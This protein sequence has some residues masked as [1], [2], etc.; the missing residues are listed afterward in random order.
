MD[1]TSLRNLEFPYVLHLEK[2]AG[3]FILVKEENDVNQRTDIPEDW[4]GVVLKTE[5]VEE[6]KEAETEQKY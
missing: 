4:S 2:G 5:A 1:K 3:T 6:V